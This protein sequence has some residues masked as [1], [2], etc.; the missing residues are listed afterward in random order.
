MDDCRGECAGCEEQDRAAIVAGSDAAPV[1]DA[2]EH[3]LDPV[4][5]AVEVCVVRDR[6]LPTGTGGDARKNPHV[7]QDVAEPVGAVAPIPEQDCRLRDGGEQSP[8]PDVV[9]CLARREEHPD[10]ATLHIGHDMQLRVQ[11]ALRAP[12]QT[13]APPF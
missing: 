3:V 7:N 4:A 1:L 11:S 8:R 10:R 12:D 6:D 9:R 13:S 2:G 5:Q